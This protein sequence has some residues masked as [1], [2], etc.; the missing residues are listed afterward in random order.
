[1]GRTSAT[2]SLNT[3]RFFGGRIILPDQVLDRAEVVCEKGKIVAIS[4]ASRTTR[5]KSDVPSIDLQGRYLAPGFVDLHVHGGGGADFMDGTPEAVQKALEIHLQHGTTTLFP[6]TSTGTPTELARML[7]A[8]AEC[9]GRKQACRG[10]RIGGVHLYGPYFAPEKSGCHQ[11]TECRPPQH[12]EYESYFQTGLIKIATCAAELE[13]AAEFYRAARRRRCLITCGHSNASWGE[14]Q[15]AFEL[16]MRHVDHFWC[17]MSNVASVRQRLGVPMQGSMLEFVLGNPEMSTEVIAD[18]YHL[19]PELLDFAYRMKGADR[20][21]L[22]T[23]ASRALDMPA[24]NYRFGPIETGTLFKSDGNVGWAAS[25]SLASSA[26]GMDHMV[27]TMKQGS[28]ASLPEVIRMASLTPARRAGIAQ[29]TGS[30]EVGKRADLLILD[31]SLHVQGVFVDGV[32][33]L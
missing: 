16:G 14:M 3:V 18:G 25:G 5:A 30:I 24:G 26:Q 9:K 31:E 4:K 19:A 23:D 28:S 7:Q 12:R 17:A 6:T 32:P 20:L 21:C 13:G 2:P 15:S 10:A 33:R 27:R 22:V 29:Q 11:S 8:V 1:M